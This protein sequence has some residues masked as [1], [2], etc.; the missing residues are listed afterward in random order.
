M[1][2][3]A[4][5]FILLQIESI[6]SSVRDTVDLVNRQFEE[7]AQTKSKSGKKSN[8]NKSVNLSN[9]DIN[10][11]LGIVNKYTEQ[12]EGSIAFNFA[13]G[14]KFLPFDNHTL[15]NIPSRKYY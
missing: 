2:T 11:L 12:V 14:Q 15:Q 8:R 6:L 5:L 10:K 4:T 3:E 1:Y 13:G 7:T 9:D